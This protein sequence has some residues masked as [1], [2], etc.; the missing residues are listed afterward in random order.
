MEENTSPSATTI[1]ITTAEITRIWLWVSVMM[2]ARSTS[3]SSR[4]TAPVT[5]PWRL[6][7]M[8]QLLRKASPL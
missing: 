6:M 7:G 4:Y 5:A 8:A 3:C 2:S 1:R